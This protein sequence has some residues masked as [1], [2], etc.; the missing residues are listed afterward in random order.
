VTITLSPIDNFG[1][2]RYFR[3]E[4][5][6]VWTNLTRPIRLVPGNYELALGHPYYNGIG[7]EA[8]SIRIESLQH[9]KGGRFED[10]NMSLGERTKITSHGV[11]IEG[12]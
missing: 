9:R 3:K 5:E 1:K 4:N 2:T 8:T 6:R 12:N 10:T 7:D 11:E